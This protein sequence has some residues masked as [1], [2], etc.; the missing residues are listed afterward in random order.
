VADPSVV[1]P[2]EDAV[3]TATPEPGYMFASWQ[4]TRA[5]IPFCDERG[6]FDQLQGLSRLHLKF[7]KW[8]GN[9]TRTVINYRP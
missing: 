4:C 1:D 9:S 5:S 7:P 6:H 8:V 3:L 2:E